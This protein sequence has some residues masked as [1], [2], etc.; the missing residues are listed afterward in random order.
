MALFDVAA[1]L[2][3]ENGCL[4]KVLVGEG[5]ALGVVVEH[6]CLHCRNGRMV[7]GRGL[8]VLV[9]LLLKWDGRAGCDILR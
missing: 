5:V 6:S 3:V 4:K 2:H 8:E 7:G 1:S 9:D